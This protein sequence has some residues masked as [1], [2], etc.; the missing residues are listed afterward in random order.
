MPS[1]LPLVA[2]LPHPDDEFA[3]LPFLSVAQREG[4]DLHLVWLTDGAAAG[5]DPGRRQAESEG[6]VGR[7]GLRPKTMRFIGIER[8]L[9]DGYLH[10]HMDRALLAVSDVL[11]G[12]PAEVELLLPAW[13]GGH[14]DH[15]AA[16]ALGRAWARGR[17]AAM[18][19][20]PA[21]QGE[22]WG[23][24]WFEVLAPTTSMQVVA[25]QRL[26]LRDSFRLLRTCL[27]YRS[28]WRSFLGLLP[29]AALHL[30]IL[31]RPIVL[32]A[33]DP[34]APMTRPHAGLLLYERRTR[35]RWDV[36]RDALAG[37]W[38]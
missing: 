29:M 24:P 20:F 25:Q 33:V 28:Q 14:Q 9:P 7:F 23:G 27:G 18:R 30:V 5:S 36:V 8:G 38:S 26:G 21:Y 11:E 22:R 4:R 37:Y 15:D 3:I 10:E 19:Q 31:R 34:D 12:L 32:C 17:S 13:E 2:L 35:W 6:V 16:H 1:D